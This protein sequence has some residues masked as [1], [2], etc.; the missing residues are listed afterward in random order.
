MEEKNSTIIKINV[1]NVR[2]GNIAIQQRIIYAY[3][4]KMEK[5]QTLIKMN[6]RH[7]VL[8]NTVIFQR[9]LFVNYVQKDREQTARK[10]DVRL[11]FFLF[12]VLL[13]IFSWRGKVALVWE[14]A[15]VRIIEIAFG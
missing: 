11:I 7:V 14:K 10:L 2:K 4:V 13:V 3:H 9:I 15:N 6:V 8:G 1:Q 12:L 5:N